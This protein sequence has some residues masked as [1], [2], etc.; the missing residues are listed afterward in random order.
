[1]HKDIAQTHVISCIYHI[2]SSEDAK[3]WPIVIEDYVGNTNAIVLKPGDLVLY[4]SAKNCHGRPY[5]F[6]GSWYTSVFVH[7]YP[8]ENWG[9]D[10]GLDANFAVPLNYQDVL[11]IPYPKLEMRRTT[12]LEPDCP[13]YWCNLKDAVHWEGPGE[14]GHVMT[15][16]GRRYPLFPN[17]NDG[18]DRESQEL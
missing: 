2:A 6:D 16:G 17:K 10:R 4:E 5:A 3:A 7:Y 15:A 1:M 9:K 13:D 14:Y 18:T 12:M 11:P 8:K